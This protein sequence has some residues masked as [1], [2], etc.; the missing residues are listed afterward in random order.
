MQVVGGQPNLLRRVLDDASRT[1][2]LNLDREYLLRICQH[3]LESVRQWIRRVPELDD[4]LG[5]LLRGG[6]LSASE[7]Q[8]LLSS[9][10]LR[11]TS[12]GLK[13]RYPLYEDYLREHR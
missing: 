9:G 11:S 4:A 6:Q 5:R 3:H 1:G 10:L 13:L 2:V 12:T 7:R 8:H